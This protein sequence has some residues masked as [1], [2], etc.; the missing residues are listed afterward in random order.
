MELSDKFMKEDPLMTGD[1]GHGQTIEDLEREI[2]NRM[3]DTKGAYFNPNHP[4][5]KRSV[6]EMLAWNSKLDKARQRI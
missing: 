5:H 1:Q 3:A 4:D 6:D 2:N